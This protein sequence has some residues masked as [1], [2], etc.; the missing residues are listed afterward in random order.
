MKLASYSSFLA[1]QTIK[2]FKQPHFSLPLNCLISVE[3]PL[4]AIARHVTQH[5]S[6]V[7]FVASI[8]IM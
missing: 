4:L 6:N 7:P 8:S 1:N 3:D 2:I 5:A